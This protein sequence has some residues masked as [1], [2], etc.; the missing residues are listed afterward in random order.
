MTTSVPRLFVLFLLLAAS[1]FSA[2][3]LFVISQASG[4]PCTYGSWSFCGVFP[5]VWSGTGPIE[6]AGT[7]SMAGVGSV[8]AGARADFGNL[9]AI[10]S[11][12]S[13]GGAVSAAAMAYMRDTWTIT[14]G[15]PGGAGTVLITVSLDGT[16]NF[17][18]S[19][20]LGVWVGIDMPG[21]SPDHVVDVGCRT[22]TGCSPAGVTSPFDVSGT[23]SRAITFGS[24]F[25]VA[26]MLYAGT[27]ANSGAE[28]SIDA[29]SSARITGVQ[30]LDQTGRPVP[31]FTLTAESGHDYLAAGAVPEPASWALVLA[32]AGAFLLGRGRYRRGRP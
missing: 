11:A 2:P 8:Y 29:W 1:A 25:D 16:Y 32:A 22:D 13:E 4:V 14:G 18:W 30:V 5:E 12:T 31:G 24:P 20:N 6:G 19:S 3:Q 27:G 15:A 10:M 17:Q 28:Q 7:S 23:L 9:G 21:G 26:F